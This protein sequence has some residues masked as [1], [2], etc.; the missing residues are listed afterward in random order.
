MV[1]TDGEKAKVLTF[2]PESS[3]AISLPTPLK[4]T[5]SKNVE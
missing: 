2:L 5:D 1:I 3:M 4:W